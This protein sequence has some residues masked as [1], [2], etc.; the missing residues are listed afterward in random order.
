MVRRREEGSGE[1]LRRGGKERVSVVKP[2]ARPPS[3]PL[4]PPPSSISSFS[5]GRFGTASM[6]ATPPLWQSPIASVKLSA[7]SVS[8]SPA[9]YS[10]IFSSRVI[11]S[12]RHAHEILSDGNHQANFPTTY[13]SLSK[14]LRV[15]K[16]FK[17][18]T[19]CDLSMKPKETMQ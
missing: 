19:V 11:R 12:D 4:L 8:S 7:M 15:D 18:P 10:L 5:L 14:T 13:L 3:P 17:K 6:D 1:A 16:G 9:K 2:A